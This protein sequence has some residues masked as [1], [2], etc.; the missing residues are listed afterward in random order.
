MRHIEIAAP[1]DEPIADEDDALDEEIEGDDAE[2]MEGAD[3]DD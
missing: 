2:L 1:A 3:A